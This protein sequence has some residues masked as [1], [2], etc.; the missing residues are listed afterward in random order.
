MQQAVIDMVIANFAD[1]ETLARTKIAAIDDMQRL[2]HL[3]VDLSIAHTR[4]QMEQVL[5]SLNV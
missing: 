5:R 4:E 1:L 3:I 2:Q